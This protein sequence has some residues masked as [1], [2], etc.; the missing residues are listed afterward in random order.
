LKRVAAALLLALLCGP[1][2]AQEIHDWS[3]V[4]AVE[5][6]ARPGPALWHLTRG[7]S[8]VW[9][10]GL[11]G[12]LP[13]DLDWNKDYVAELLT[14]A[15][16]ILMPPRADVGLVD[17]AW[18][19]L[20][21]G[22]ELSLPRGQSLEAGLAEPL[23]SRFIA[24]R[25]AVGGDVDDYNTDIPIRA[26]FRLQQNLV[27]REKLR[28]GEPR[29]SIEKMANR[30]RIPN[31]PVLQVSAMD[32]IRDVLKLDAAQQR[33]CLA[34]AVEDV[35]WALVHARSAAQAWAVGD[36]KG[37]K[38][39]YTQSRLFDCMTVAVGRIADISARGA[40]D[41]TGAIDAAL[42]KP[43]KTIAVMNVA[44]LLR[45]GGVLERLKAR[46]VS[47]EGPAD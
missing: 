35:Q 2:Q 30:A 42:N 9:I 11:A 46:Q 13:E 45:K 4:E 5:V 14:G 47:I 1:A 34:E 22:S 26:A 10:L 16:A 32:S 23:K 33:A 27:K 44:Q 6:K 39:N 36:I 3:D 17:A 21:H 40:A 7:D 38:A 19:L 43:G 24:A 25:N 41:Y 37:V 12:P 18:F 31:A 28:Y 29:E 8:E 20:W 15:R